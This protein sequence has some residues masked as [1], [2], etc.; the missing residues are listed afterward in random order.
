MLNL[1]EVDL[2]EGLEAYGQVTLRLGLKT[3][4]VHRPRYV[5]DQTVITNEHERD[6]II[7]AYLLESGS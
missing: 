3:E 1:L 5:G 6:L 2:L 7:V 4:I